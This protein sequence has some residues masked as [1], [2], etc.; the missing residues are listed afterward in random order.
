MPYSIP[1]STKILIYFDKSTISVY[2]SWHPLSVDFLWCQE[3]TFYC[4]PRKKRYT[5]LPTHSAAQSSKRLKTLS[6]TIL[7]WQD[8]C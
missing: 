3:Y 5:L 2:F 1:S 8:H 4:I 6:V 7:L